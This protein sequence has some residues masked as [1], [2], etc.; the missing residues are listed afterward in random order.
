MRRREFS[1]SSSAA[2]PSSRVADGRGLYHTP[3]K[4]RCFL[5]VA[6]EGLDIGV[7]LSAVDNRSSTK[8]VDR[9]HQTYRRLRAKPVSLPETTSGSIDDEDRQGSAERQA[10]H[11]AG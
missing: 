4:I 2:P 3:K 1:P 7:R 11:T 10:G 8:P 9:V 6:G 5:W